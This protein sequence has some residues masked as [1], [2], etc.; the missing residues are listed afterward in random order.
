MEHI[1][2]WLCQHIKYHIFCHALL[3]HDIYYICEV[4]IWILHI[5]AWLCQ[6]FDYHH[7]FCHNFFLYIWFWSFCHIA[8]FWET[9]IIFWE[10]WGL[11]HT[12]LAAVSAWFLC[13]SGANLYLK[14]Q[15]NRTEKKKK[16]IL[17]MQ[18]CEPVSW[19]RLLVHLSCK[20][21]VVQ[22][23][24]SLHICDNFQPFRHGFQWELFCLW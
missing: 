2:V 20:L 10:S 18:I 3:P 1:H 8:I 14:S 4:I 19:T 11:V 22:N 23:A 13:Y 7:I 17:K 9:C 12:C 6:H 21:N 16:N 15:L 5:Y 24:C